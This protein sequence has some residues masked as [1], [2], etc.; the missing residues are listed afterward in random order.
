M[1]Q[2]PVVVKI[3]GSTLGNHDTTLQD[4]VTLQRDGVKL[5]VVHGGGDL[6]SQ[7]MQR[8]GT[9]PKFV[10]GLRVTDAESLE[11]VVAVLTGLVNK[12]LV[13]ALLSRG[14]ETIGFSGVDGGLLQARI[15]NPQLGFV[16][17]I[18]EVNAYP[19]I[20][21]M[22]AGFIP[23]IA[24]VGIHCNDGSPQAGQMLN[25][26]GDTV[27]GELAYAMEADRLIF[28]TDV[29]GVL[30]GG[31]RLIPRLTSRQARFL[32]NSGVAKG[33]MIPKLEACVRAL[34][35][36]STAEIVDG[37]RPGALLDCLSNSGK[38]TRILA[39]GRT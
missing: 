37:R 4:L 35:R 31:G 13:A 33:G 30:D 12:Q 22:E 25:I 39:A 21:A 38:G 17:E 7:W 15:A 26:N 36:V 6:I 20:Q 1:A 27:T 28:L 8:Q 19:L 3:G 24:P 14:G 16:G 5:V 32:L 34:E 29:E 11:I 10:R 18:T 23:L 2:R 9:R